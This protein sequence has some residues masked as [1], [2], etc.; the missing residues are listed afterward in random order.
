MS[1]RNIKLTISYDGTDFYGWQIQPEGRTVQ[2]EILSSLRQMHKHDVRLYAAGRTDSGVHAEGQVAN[3]LTDIDSIDS[4]RF[5]IAMNSFLPP[6]VRVLDSAAVPDDFHSRYSAKVR[7]YRYYFTVDEIVH[8]R[9]ARYCARL[10]HHPSIGRLNELCHPLIGS[11]DFSTF[12]VPREQSESKVRHVHNAA[13]FPL[14]RLLVF[15]IS[16]NAFLWRMVRSVVGTLTELDKQGRSP[17][18]VER[19]LLARDHKAA[20]PT[21]AASG[22]FLH[23]VEYPW[24]AMR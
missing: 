23:R 22:L 12:T 8:P 21:A 15:E 10:T 5:H 2:G 19:R 20:G 17:V 4:N 7:V 14:G 18:E 16:A 1:A 13:F 9:V 24:E 11:H 3:F 6:D